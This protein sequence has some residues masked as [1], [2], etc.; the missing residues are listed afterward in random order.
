M[1]DISYR[2]GHRVYR[3]HQLKQFFFWSFWNE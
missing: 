2:S 1:K 3:T